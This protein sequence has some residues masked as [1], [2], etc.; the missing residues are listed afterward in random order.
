MV[1][2][3]LISAF[4][5]SDSLFIYFFVHGHTVRHILDCLA[6]GWVKDDFAVFHCIAEGNVSCFHIMRSFP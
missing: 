1:F 2:S 3:I 4:L 6:F 5:F